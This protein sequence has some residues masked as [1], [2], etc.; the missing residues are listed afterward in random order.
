MSYP[1]PSPPVNDCTPIELENENQ[2]NDNAIQNNKSDIAKYKQKIKK[3]VFENKKLYEHFMDYLENSDDDEYCLQEIIKNIK[4]FKYEGNK[5]KFEEFLRLISCIL[6]NY[7]RKE[8]LYTKIFK[9]LQYYRDQIKQTFSNL[10]IFNIFQNNKLIFIYLFENQI[11]TFDDDIY[12]E[13]MSKI[14]S[15]GIRYCHFFYPEVKKF[16]GEEKVK[17]IENE[18]LLLN[19]KIFENFDEK[20]HEGENDSYICSL[21]RQDSVEEFIIY[22]N[23]TNISLKSEIIT[24]LFE[25]NSVLIENQ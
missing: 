19:P 11:I 20:R 17:D 10:E 6:I 22:V 23:Q 5:K 15:N 4:K 16:V 2:Q 25:T 14:E 9:L 18:L 12:K 7:H 24:S 3:F 8:S 21:I 1:I 13:I